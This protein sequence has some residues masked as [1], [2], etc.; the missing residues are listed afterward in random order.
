MLLFCKGRVQE[1]VSAPTLEDQRRIWNSYWIV[2]V[3]V[4]PRAASTSAR[5][6]SPT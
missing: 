4:S 6:A 2:R 1:L 5:L 3:L